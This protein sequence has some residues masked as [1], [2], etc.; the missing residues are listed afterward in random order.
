MVLYNGKYLRRP[1][2]AA[3]IIAAVVSILVLAVAI[4]DLSIQV[5]SPEPDSTSHGLVMESEPTAIFLEP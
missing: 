1:A 5:L 4:V 3:M 2:W